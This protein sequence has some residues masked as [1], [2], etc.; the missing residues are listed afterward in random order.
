MSDLVEGWMGRTGG[1]RKTGEMST[2]GF[3][4]QPFQP[5]QPVLPILPNYA[6]DA[7][8]RGAACAVFRL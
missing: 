3:S 8:A 7:A 2:T 4:V 5:F 1:N 6:T